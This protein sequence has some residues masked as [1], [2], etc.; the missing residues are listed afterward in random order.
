MEENPII[1][2]I[3]YKTGRKVDENDI[4]GRLKEENEYVLP[5]SYYNPYKIQK[6]KKVIQDLLFEKG[7]TSAVVEVKTLEKG[8]NEFE[9]IFDINEGPRVKVGAVKFEGDPK[10]LQSVLRSAMKQTK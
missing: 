2:N 10:V 3:T 4:V 1:K 7:L 5:Y 6:V 9:V 8:K